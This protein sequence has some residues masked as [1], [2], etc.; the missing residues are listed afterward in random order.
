[1][2]IEAKPIQYSKR[3]ATADVR[4]KPIREG[5]FMVTCAAR[6][7]S[8][9]LVNLLQSHPDVMCHME[10]YNPRKVEGFSGVY[11]QRLSEE[12]DLEVRMR[13]M[14]S[15][16]PEAFIYKVAFDPQGKKCVGFK[17]KYEELLLPVFA[18]PR[19]VLVGDKE[20]VIIHLKRRNLLRRFLSWW[21][22][23]HVTGK[24]MAVKGE[25]VQKV[26]AVRLDPAACKA[27][28]DR[29]TRTATFIKRL[30]KDHEMLDIDYEDLVGPDAAG[31]HTRILKFLGLTQLPLNT[32]FKKLAEDDLSKAI[33]NFGE[34]EEY[35]RGS[36]YSGFFTEQ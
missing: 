13:A 26:P 33:S 12:P 18:G 1:M 14:R 34:L 6:T 22:V 4:P 27:D 17:F 9:M 16:Q 24:T 10:I 19:S 32:V 11:R 25:D 20:I 21:V 2:G 30:F 31:H 8:S 7:G 29:T 35:F 3:P 23:N 28:F 5:F 15:A 36:Q